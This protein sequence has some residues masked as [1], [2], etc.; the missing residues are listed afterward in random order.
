M[1]Q[2][3]SE[4]RSAGDSIPET[5]CTQ[6]T[7]WDSEGFFGTAVCVE[8]GNQDF[9]LPPVDRGKA[10]WLF[11]AAGFAIECL[12]WG[13]PYSFG[14]F[15]DYYSS[16]PPFQGQ[17]N[18]A[19]IGTSGMGIMYLTTPILIAFIKAFGRWA[20]W[21]PMLGLVIMVL[22]LGLSS[23]SQTTTHL[24]FTQGIL[25]GIGGGITYNPCM[26]YMDEWF[27]KRK[28]LAY[29]IM[30]SGTGLAGVVV[31]LLMEYLLGRLGFRNALR[32]WAGVLFVVAAP[33]VWFI[34]PRV[35]PSANTR[36]RLS[37]LRFLGALSFWLY[38]SANI[39]EGLGFFVPNIYLPT[40]VHNLFG[41]GSF[42]AASTV[43]L[44]NISSVFGCIA[45]GMLIDRLHVTTCILVST[46]GATVGVLV[47]WGLSP[48]V[49]VLYIFCVM[50]GLFAGSF[51]STWPGIMMNMARQHSPDDKQGQRTVTVMVFG[52]LAVG[53]GIGNV[54]TGPLS[55]SL[56][57]GWPWRG[58][59]S[60]VG[61]GSGYGIMIV[62]T[63]ITALLGGSTFVWRRLGLL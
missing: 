22:A 57:R 30:W 26:M 24:I 36:V 14:V 43:I 7:E 39:V 38:Q 32:V 55:E 35:P 13:L 60:A 52:F 20:R 1:S 5:P 63:G 25:Y 10:A 46:I 4:K 61:Y 19:L 18:I 31:P 9:S 48:S 6:S 2:V 56:V 27:D 40:Y 62:F 21:A 33:F 23:L 17:P 54:A 41:A 37:D 58:E 15:Q 3:D 47:I 42:T 28:G 29:G 11:L 51:T 45:M 59:T 50:Y 12:V 16:H 44:I 34:Q 53:R 49:S 8:D